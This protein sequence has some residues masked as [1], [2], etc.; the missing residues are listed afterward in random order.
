MHLRFQG[1]YVYVTRGMLVLV[2]NEDELAL[3]LAHE[4]IHVSQRHSVKQM[5]KGILPSI[6]MIPGNVIGAVA[7]QGVGDVINV[8]IVGTSNLLLANYSRKHETEADNLGMD[9]AAKAGYDPAVLGGILQRLAKQTEFMSGELEKKSF[10][11][12]H[13]Y[14]P[15]RVTNI[16]TK[17]AK[18]TAGKTYDLDEKKFLPK[19]RG[20]VFGPNPEQGVFHD[21]ILLH[22]PLSFAWITPSQWT[23]VNTPEAA[24]AVSK[25]E[26]ALVMITPLTN[27]SSYKAYANVMRK[28]FSSSTSFNIVADIDTLMN[29]IPGHLFRMNIQDNRQTV[30][31]EIILLD[32]SGNNFQLTG[33]ST[34][35]FQ[36]MIHSSLTSF[37]EITSEEAQSV[38]LK[39]I[40]VVSANNN[41]TIETLSKRTGSIFSLSETKLV[42]NLNENPALKE[43]Q[44]IKVLQEKTFTK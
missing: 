11:S 23:T 5:N 8:P 32:Y 37:R 40:D 33:L 10:L 18:L 9:L 30:F 41:E 4:I 13:P 38:K 21:S 28:R 44:L 42:N 15:S 6:L 25:N 26:D 17:S 16:E 14:T 39:T 27:D 2:Q 35:S 24:G 34:P 19:L 7:G 43:G 3:I 22:V 1:G 12:T 20:L 31:V 29:E 36:K